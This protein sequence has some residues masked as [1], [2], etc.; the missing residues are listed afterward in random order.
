MA[1]IS[2]RGTDESELIC[3]FCGKDAVKGAYHAFG[4]DATTVICAACAI[5][6]RVLGMLMGDA[7][8]DIIPLR[9]IPDLSRGTLN[10]VIDNTV[11]CLHDSLTWALFRDRSEK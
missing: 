11:R 1:R 2:D 4:I 9:G 8:A 5:E 6:G 10:K 7:V 3:S